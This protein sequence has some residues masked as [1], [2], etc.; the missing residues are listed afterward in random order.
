MTANGATWQVHDAAQ[1]GLDTGSLRTVSNSGVQGFGNIIVDVSTDPRMDGEMM[2]GFGLRFDGLDRF[3]TTQ[4]VNLGGISITR[5]LRIDRAENWGRFFDTF[6]NTTGAPIDVKVSFGGALGYNSGANQSVVAATSSGDTAITAEDAWTLVTTGNA[7][8]RP[9]GV[10][11]GSPTVGILGMGNH[12]LDPFA[13]PLPATGNA[14]NFYGYVSEFTVE[15]GQTKSLARFV[16]IGATGA[17]AAA[18]TQA[19]VEELAEAPELGDLSTAEICSLVNWDLVELGVDPAECAAVAPLDIPPAPGDEAPKTSS[20]YDVV[21]KTIA[22]L[23]ADMEAG[24]TTS[25]EITRAYLDRIRVYDTGQFGFH[26]YIHVAEDAIAQARAADRARRE[27]ATGELLGIPIAI[28]DLYD[29]KDMPTT[30]GTLALEDWQPKRDAYQVEL[31]REAGAVIIGKANLSQFANSG[32]Y[33]E[34]GWGQ[35]WNALYPSK[36]SFGSSGGSAVAVAASMAAGAMGSQTGVSLYAPS[37]GASLATFRGT[38]GMASTRGV[39][40]LTWAQDYAGPIARSVTDLAYLLNAT[41]GTDPEDLLLTAEADEH[42]P[43]D[44][45]DYLDADALEGKRIGYI[46]S[47]FVSSYAD[48]GTGEAVMSHFAD[49]EAAG[50][51]MVEVPP[52][53][54]CGPSP[55]GNRNREGWARYIELHDDFPFPSGNELLASERNLPYNRSNPSETPRMTPEQVEAWLEYRR[56]CKEIIAAYMDEHEI[57]ALVYAGFISDMFSN[58]SASAQHSSDRGTGVITSNVGLPTVVVP[59]G[60]NPNGYSISMQLVGRAWNDAE[61][62]GMGYALEQQA[63]GQQHATT[64]PPLEYDPQLDPSPIEVEVPGE[65]VTEPLYIEVAATARIKRGRAI[66]RFANKGETRVV[67][68]LAL[69][70]RVNGKRLRLG[71]TK[72]SVAARKTVRVR[73]PLN[74]RARKA[75]GKRK[76]IAVTAVYN[77]RSPKTGARILGTPRAAFGPDAQAQ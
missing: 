13:D 46:P 59:V 38:D 23:Q 36:T 28:K 5:S 70:G 49:L 17:G 67:G 27:G 43:E 9:V 71:N 7:N 18:D 2:R 51:T 39:M 25:E 68:K 15:P 60:T 22:E 48:D 32:S 50:A 8:Q 19:V 44:W 66:V 45:T 12:E 64:A 54:S 20:P 72:L 47:S 73:V 55:G 3:K 35:V 37:T 41:T 40:P 10:V 77:L 26:A 31:L 11:T 16:A 52:T 34:S 24:V 1:P 33:S 69:R 62:L 29:T 74:T 63:Q 56:N 30:D 42:R 57:D 4:A 53:P 14:A 6:T 65:P 21:G 58:D 76:R 75:L 61:I